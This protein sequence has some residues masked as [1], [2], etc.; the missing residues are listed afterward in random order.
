MK[1]RYSDVMARTTPVN[2]QP[3]EQAFFTRDTIQVAREL[4]GCD[5]VRR[6]GDVTLVGRIV[7]TEAYLGVKDPCCHSFK[8]VLTNRT[9]SMYLPGGY[10]YV[11]FI[12]GMYHCF[13][14]V[15]QM[16]GEPEA[17]LVRALKPIGGLVRMKKNRG[18]ERLTN[19]C[20]G[21][22]KLCQALEITKSLNGKKLKSSGRDL[23]F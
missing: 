10:S 13:N 5:L 14:V 22:G 12:Y 19:L 9:Q 1:R 8:G 18:Q 20:S 7:E 4:L 11:Y 17:V 6:I 21:P 23:H 3:L 16:E 15:T 2:R